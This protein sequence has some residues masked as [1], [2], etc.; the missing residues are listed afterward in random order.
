MNLMPKHKQGNLLHANDFK[1]MILGAN[2]FFEREKERINALNVFPVP[3]G[4]TGTNMS[5]TLRAAMEGS[6]AYEGQSIGELSEIVAS[7]ALL[8]ARGNS[9]VILSQ[10]LRGIA[11]GLRKKDHIS[12]AELS[13]AFQ[14]GVVYAYKAVSKPVEGTILTVSRE[15]ARGI[16]SAA[17]KGKNLYDSLEEAVNSGK[18]ALAKTTD[19]LP[20]LKEAGVVDAGGL[21]LLV[22]FEGCLYAMK[23]SFNDMLNHRKNHLEEATEA[24]ELSTGSAVGQIEPFDLEFP[25]CTELIIKNENGN[26]DELENLLST[27]GDSLLVADYNKIAKVHIHTASPGLVLQTGQKFGTLHDIKIDNMIDQ[28]EGTSIRSKP[29][30]ENR[31]IMHSVSPHEKGEAGLISVSFGEGF[32]EIFLSLGAD[33]IVYGGQTMNPNVEDLFNAV[34]NLPQ[35][36]AIIL[37]NN[38]NIILVAQQVKALAKKDVEV[39]ETR[40]LPE[41]LAALVTFNPSLTTEENIENMQQSIKE[42]K[43]GLITY[44]T[45]DT[46]VKEVLIQAGQFLGLYSDKIISAGEDLHEVALELL[47]EIVSEENDIITVFYGQDVSNR[48]AA[49]LIS[50]ITGKYPDHEIEPQYGGQP[51]YYYIFSVE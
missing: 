12:P 8:G 6:M 50:A 18:V 25:Y 30:D 26:F 23:K 5:M 47:D 14:Y 21:G 17:R 31:F 16:R 27:L 37:P 7:K 51:I 22:F 33:E 9:G 39:L 36:K 15:M 3:D 35:Q 43:T 44:A 2:Y 38:K 41:G 1:K 4:D 46:T 19:M 28:H 10:I 13:K 20:A 29:V 40:S 42:V 34:E 45:R 48:E 49:K 32:R 11:H 24:S